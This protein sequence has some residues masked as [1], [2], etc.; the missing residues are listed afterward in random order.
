M[1]DNPVPPRD[2]QPQDLM[3]FVAYHG[4]DQAVLIYRRS[5]SDG[6]C[7]GVTYVGLTYRDGQIAEQCGKLV[8]QIIGMKVDTVD[9]DKEIMLAKRE[10]A[11]GPDGGD[12][13]TGKRIIFDAIDKTRGPKRAKEVQEAARKKR[14]ESK[15]KHDVSETT[16]L[17]GKIF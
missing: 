6:D 11:G 3:R 14:P 9:I 4:W 1:S 15:G 10:M 7:E 12:P 5:E 13:D 8:K 2:I 17:L 16:K